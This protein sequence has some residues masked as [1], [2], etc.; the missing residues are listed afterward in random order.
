MVQVAMVTGAGSGIGCAV[1]TRLAERGSVVIL[2]G[3]RRDELER[4]AEGM[5]GEVVVHPGDVRNPEDLRS[6]AAAAGDNGGVSLL[7]NNAGIMPIAPASA[8]M[9][10][11]WKDTIDVNVTGAMNAIHAV[12]PSM[13]RRGHG[14]IVNISSV[15]GQHPFPSA[16]VYSGSKAALDSISEGLRAEF[17]ADMKRG[18]PRIRVTSIAPGAVTTNLTASIRDADT[19]A[20]TRA[21]Y[22]AMVHPLTADDVADAVLYAVEA[23]AHVCISNLTIRPTAMTR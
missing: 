22:A 6:A 17:A 14:H 21:Y 7:I 16:S 12:L 11:D 23:P 5:Q 19:R 8:A 1:A 10:D 3:R 4:A 18:G 20:G 15:A 2:V 9:L 13:Q